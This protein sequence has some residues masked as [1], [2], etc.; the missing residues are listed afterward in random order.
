MVGPP[1]RLSSI[2]CIGDTFQSWDNSFNPKKN[3]K[4][5][6]M[7]SG[8]DFP[9][10]WKNFGSPPVY[11][12]LKCKIEELIFTLVSRSAIVCTLVVICARADSV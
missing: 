1:R 5:W 2:L 12:G 10:V 9:N 3:C 7:K 6:N 4:I 8:A 11:R